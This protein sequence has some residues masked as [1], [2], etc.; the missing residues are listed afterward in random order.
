MRQI[1]QKL[2]SGVMRILEAPFPV[3]NPGQ[4]T[5]RNLYSVISAGSEGATVKAARAG[6]AAKAAARPEEVKQAIESVKTRG[7]GQT[8]RAVMKKLGAHSP[9]GYSCVGEVIEVGREVSEFKVGDFAA[10]GGKTACHAEIVSVGANL[11]V[12][13]DRQ[14]DL[15]Q[16]AYNT[17]GAI[18]MQGVRQADLRLGESCA[19]IGLGLVGQLTCI[20]LRAA[21]VRVVGVDIDDFAVSL[22]A[23]HSADLALNRHEAAAEWRIMDFS[24]GYGCDA[25]II[26]ASSTSLDPINFAG[27]ISRK[28]ATIVVVGS[29]PT[30]FSREPH[31]YNK[32]LTLKMSCSYGP[33]RYDPVYE[34]KG[35]D[36]P[37]AYVRWT[38][39]R[40]ME[41]FQDLIAR[42]VIDVGCLTTH[43]FGLEEAPAAYRMIVER[44][45]PYLG[46]L[47]EYDAGRQLCRKPVIVST[48]EVR[49]GKVNIGFIGAGSYACGQ[50]LPHI[51]AGPDVVLKTVM[52]NTGASGR[53]VA[54]RF[55]FQYCTGE[56]ED[57]LE[58]PEINT[59]FIATRHDTH[60]RY[61]LES[62][63]AGKNVFVEKPLCLDVRELEEIREICSD[64]CQSM[65]VVGFNRRFAPLTGELT[66]LMGTGKMSMTYRVNAGA[67]A[68]G[69]WLLDPE[70][71]GGRILGEVCHF[72]DYFNFLCGSYPVRVHAEAFEETSCNNDTVAISIKY[73]NGS[74]GAVQYFA[75]GS[76]SLAKER[77]EVY[78]GGLTA[79]LDDFRDLRVYGGQK[80]F[81]RRLFSQDKGQK[82]QVHSFIEA[83][84]GGLPPP[85]PLQS[86][87]RA[88]ES[89]FKVLDSIRTAR[90]M[91]I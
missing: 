20:L 45:E 81:H 29:V 43:T 41:A 84:R 77:V 7:I 89:T 72:M 50:L 83:I 38:E 53:G 5:V 28:K 52:T 37:Q 79:V 17:L 22:A 10:C 88:T 34:Q 33:G 32:E 23:R 55:G 78:R 27:A 35:R 15:K 74:L 57:I 62:L 31:F 19:V 76:K 9:L 40:N 11:C 6:F 39:K 47:I 21:G 90:A 60:G 58:N 61:V 30:G 73:A 68:P 3:S 91:E 70:T 64:A 80:T 12:K 1:T 36:Y 51:P 75:N 71:G 16:S 87:F 85:I 65:L 25:V 46:I 86:I 4:V 69:S 56:V 48:K 59:V 42:R 54:D 2:G 18:A 8:C 49:S 82:I 67:V 26:A 66:R 13:V 63:R 44:S 14:A 24:G